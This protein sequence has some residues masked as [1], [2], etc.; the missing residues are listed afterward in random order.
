MTIY[1]SC[2]SHAVWLVV[3]SHLVF[4]WAKDQVLAYEAS[5]YTQRKTLLHPRILLDY[6]EAS[7]GGKKYSKD[8]F[9]FEWNFGLIFSL[10]HGSLT[11]T[12]TLPNSHFT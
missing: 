2:T 3:S 4:Y 1:Q 11:L 9:S 6:E 12:Y 10:P 5:L 8:S 7:K